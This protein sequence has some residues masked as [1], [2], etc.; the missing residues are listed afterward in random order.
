MPMSDDEQLDLFALISGE[1]TGRPKAA[2][3]ASTKRRVTAA[4]AVERPSV[5]DAVASS[6]SDDEAAPTLTEVAAAEAAAPIAEPVRK[7]WSVGELVS[8]VRGRIER[9]FAGVYV[10]GEISNCRPAASGHVY[11]TLKDGAAQ[12]R[13][14]MFRGRAQLLRFKLADGLQVIVRGKVTIYEDRGE[15]QMVAE[16]MEPMGAGALQI[17]F[18]Q[19]KAKLAGE[20][21]FAAERK[22]TLP[23]LPRSIGVV[24]SPTGAAVM[25]MLNILRRRCDWMRVVIYPAQVQGEG[26]AAEVVSGVEYFNQTSEV[27]LIIVARG[28]GSAEDLAAFN[29]ERLARAVAASQIPVISAVGHETDFTICDFVADLRAPTPSAAAEL[30]AE[31][32]DAL[33]ERETSLRRRLERAV[34]Y[35][36]MSARQRLEALSRHGVF[37][38]MGAQLARRQQRVDELGFRL[39]DAMRRMLRT[40]AEALQRSEAKVRH[41]DLR[42]RLESRRREL[43]SADKALA[44]AMRALLDGKRAQLKAARGELKALSPVAILERGYALVFDDEGRLVKNPAQMKKGDKLRARVAHGEIAATVDEVSEKGL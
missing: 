21:L 37:A 20:G 36:M 5:F 31:S 22:K 13:V 25:D 19:L 6:V 35:R 30:A 18:E 10:E 17:A 39:S 3:R 28:G 1:A 40:K 26:A 33:A 7:V 24:T 15:L 43:H 14:V 2:R 34:R 38:G 9:D 27:E 12:M 41:L 23:A 44:S 42:T 11:L 4:P 8:A 16:H 32:K 29:D